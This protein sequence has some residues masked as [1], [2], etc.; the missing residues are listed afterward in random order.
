VPMS[1]GVLDENDT[2][3]TS[4]FSRIKALVE[5]GCQENMDNMLLSAVRMYYYLRK[6]LFFDKRYTN[7]SK[8]D[9]ISSNPV[10]HVSML[11]TIVTKRAIL[12][13]KEAEKKR[14]THI[15]F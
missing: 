9:Q 15:I 6:V 11:V 4:T 5:S 2:I 7:I 8:F 13:L 1:S 12:H 10:K 3:F 14:G